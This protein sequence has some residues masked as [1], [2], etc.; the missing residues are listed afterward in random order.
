MDEQFLS[1]AIRLAVESVTNGGGPFGAVIVNEGKIIAR[2]TNRVTIANDPTAHAEIVAIRE[3]GQAIA[4]F[5]L[6]GCVLY[7]SCEPCP[8]CLSACYWARLSEIIYAGGQAEAAAAGFDDAF[9]YQELS[10]PLPARGLPIRRLLADRGNEPFDAWK[11]F[12]GRV[13]Y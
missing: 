11:N 13:E 6:A 10:L 1:E 8:M 5:S 7:T 3:A 9:L 4:S 12:P 2:G